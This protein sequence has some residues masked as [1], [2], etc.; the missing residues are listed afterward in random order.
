[1][2]T[3]EQ[4]LNNLEQVQCQNSWK[5]HVAQLLGKIAAWYKCNHNPKGSVTQSKGIDRDTQNHRL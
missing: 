2:Y 5:D 4:L 3:N 1:M